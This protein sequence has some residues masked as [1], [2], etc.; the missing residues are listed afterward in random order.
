MAAVLWLVT[1]GVVLMSGVFLIRP[2]YLRR[3]ALVELNR[4]G[5]VEIVT[6][7]SVQFVISSEVEPDSAALNRLAILLERIDCR[8]LGLVPCRNLEDLSPLAGLNGLTLLDLRGTH[9]A[10]LSPLAGLS[11]MT[12]L[13][14]RYT[15]VSDLSPLAGLT[16]LD[17]LDLSDTRVSD[18]S[19]LAGLAGLKDLESIILWKDQEVRITDSLERVIKR[20]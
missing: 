17:Y 19:P 6:N 20:Y 9:V 4:L 16:G 2:W 12:E 7:G 13:Y 5:R 3:A 10:D 18:L 11:R 14:L 1:L 8:R 15:P